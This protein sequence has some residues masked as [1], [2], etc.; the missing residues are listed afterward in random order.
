MTGV[1]PERRLRVLYYYWS[2]SFDT[3]SPKVLVGMIDALD[4][5]RVTPLFWAT[6]D[7][8]LVA[9]L[10]RRDVELLRGPAGDVSWRR[11]L[12]AARRVIGKMRALRRARIDLLHIHEFGWNQDLAIAAWLLRVPVILHVHNPLTVDRQNLHRLIARAVLFVSRAHLEQT[13]H[14]RLIASRARVLHNPID[15]GHYASGH[16]RRAELGL[17][18]SDVVVLAVGQLVPRKGLDVLIEVARRL[19]PTNPDL[20]FLV[21][22]PEKDTHRE[23]AQVL[24][25]RAA[26][27][28]LGGR[29]RFLGSRS[30]VPDLL[31]SA[32]IFALPTRDEPFGLVIAE[33]MAAS[34]PVVATSIGGIP[35]VVGDSAAGI[36]L[37]PG[38]TDGFIREIGRLAASSTER[39][40]RGGRGRAQ[41]EREFGYAV[42]GARLARLYDEV[43]R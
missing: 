4:R 30:D 31:A 21:A 15:V 20:Q 5:S 18:E 9:Q 35:E 24:L 32:D 39:R 34:L 3:G 7:G 27:P 40:E 8:P 25:S 13:E 38:D 29:F 19:L 43:T 37:E 16:S 33:A 22:G 6:G 2:L 14:L 17:A 42:F 26:D 36:L 41:V 1:G 12:Q 28:E 11:P 10:A 23:H